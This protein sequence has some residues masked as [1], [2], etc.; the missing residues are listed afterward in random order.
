MPPG[1]LT[2]PS[3]TP[4]LS[5]SANWLEGRVRATFRSRAQPRT[6]WRQHTERALLLKITDVERI[7]VDVPFTPRQQRITLRTVYNWSILELCKVTTDSGHVGWGETVIHYTYGRVTD[8][9]VERVKGQS[10]AALMNDDTLGAGL[11]MALFDVVGKILEVPAYELM[12]SRMREWTPI[13]W[14]CSHSSP[15]DWAAEAAEAVEN[16]YTSLKNKPRPW[17]DIVAQVEAIIDV[18]PPH[19]KLDLDPNG[20]FQ[21]AAAAIPIIKRLE[22]Y[23]SVAMFETPIPQGDVLGYRQIHQSIHR[24]LALHFGNP[25]YITNL[26]EGLCDGY[27]IGG[28]KSVVVKQGTLS[29]E[30][31]MP[32]WLQIVGNGLTTTWAAHLG[33]VLT[34]AT[35]PTISC[36]NLYSHQL[37]KKRIEIVGGY[38]KVPEGPGLGVEI[39]EEAVDRHR[40]PDEALEPFQQQGQLYAHPPPRQINTVVF[41]DGRCVHMAGL[42]LGYFNSQGPAYTEGVR[43][44]SRPDDG[45]P[46]WADLFERV[47][48]Q[49]V[50]DRWEAA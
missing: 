41:P 46:E 6:T 45:T 10:P 19:F 8:Q 48:H 42:D 18:V 13:S 12:G 22:Q 11:Q 43:V 47:Q 39:D 25:P 50:K 30:A 26:R 16:G 33:A 49:P 44:E 2:R 9:T 15:E 21:N 23:D 27:V 34:H 38:Q 24:P 40:I 35:W 14:W 31:G 32:F 4:V 36:I 28:G 29:A 17:W 3:S 20:S 37:L 7:L 5:A 1:Q